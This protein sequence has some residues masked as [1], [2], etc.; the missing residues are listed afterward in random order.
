MCIKIEKKERDIILEKNKN[1]KRGCV[2]LVSA[3]YVIYLVKK[4][5][6]I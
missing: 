2:F 4:S 5:V 6:N 3:K 1:N